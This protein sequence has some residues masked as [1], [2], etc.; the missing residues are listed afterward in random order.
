MTIF[1]FSKKD[2]ALKPV[3]N[4]I[5]I[6]IEYCLISQLGKY[7]EASGDIAYLDISLLTAADEKKYTTQLKKKCKYSA[8]GIIDPKGSIKDSSALFFAGASDYLGP[9]A[10]KVVD[11][12]HFKAAASWRITQGDEVKD[13][14]NAAV[15]ALLPKTGIKLP[16]GKF[17]GWK[18][19]PSGKVMNFYLLYCSLH[20]KTALNAL[21]GEAAYTQLYQRMIVYLKQQ[22]QEAECQLWI[23]SGKDCLFLLPPKLKCAGA[24]ITSCIRM[25]L[26]APLIANE[27]FNLRVAV[28]FVF[29]LHYGSVSY[30][31]P[32]KTGTVVSDAMN[33]IYH[34]GA[35][36]TEIGRIAVSSE[37]PDGSIPAP[38]EDFFVSNGSFENRKIWHTKKFSYLQPWI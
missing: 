27:T 7:Q 28:N 3:F 31:P 26:S 29:A 13:G 2:A 4:K 21:L 1:V 10:L 36:K 15:P 11:V 6:K 5:K 20:A 35:K 38:L 17:P 16:A 8:W 25:L 19:L 23:D 32:G 33:F 24:A 14:E 12:K 30:H 37:L 34:L 18:A 9:S 22:F